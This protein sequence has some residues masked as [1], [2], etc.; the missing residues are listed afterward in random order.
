MLGRSSKIALLRRFSPFHN[1]GG[2]LGSFY[3]LFVMRGGRK[4]YDGRPSYCTL[5]WWYLTARNS[6]ENIFKISAIQKKNTKKNFKVSLSL[7]SKVIDML[8]GGGGFIKRSSSTYFSLH[9]LYTIIIIFCL[10][11][12]CFQTAMN[13]QEN[14]WQSFSHH[15]LLRF[16]AK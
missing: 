8:R 6:L 12:V 1:G 14:T 11:F 2:F 4:C 3:A 15:L 10:F 13:L 9:F 16:F 7:P 5:S